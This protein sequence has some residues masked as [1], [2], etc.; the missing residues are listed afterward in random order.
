MVFLNLNQNLLNLKN[1]KKCLD[2]EE[3]QKECDKYLLLSINHEKSFQEVKK[4]TYSIVDDKRCYT[5]R[6]ESIPWN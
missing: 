2:G 4:L 3:Y 1:I 5:N 6:N